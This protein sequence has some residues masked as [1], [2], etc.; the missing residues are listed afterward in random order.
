ML[1][2]TNKLRI[3]KLQIPSNS[4]EYD[5]SDSFPFDCEPRRNSVGFIIERKTVTTIIFKEI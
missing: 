1:Q 5:R 4:K 3:T 2:A